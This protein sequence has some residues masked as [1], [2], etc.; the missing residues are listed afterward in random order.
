MTKPSRRS[1]RLRKT[2][3]RA[4]RQAETRLGV[5]GEELQC[6][7]K[8]KAISAELDQ[9]ND[10]RRSSK[11]LREQK[12]PERA[13]IN[14]TTKI[15]PI[16]TIKAAGGRK[17][18]MRSARNRP[19]WRQHDSYTTNKA[20]TKSKKSNITA[21]K[22]KQSIVSEARR[23]P[24][25]II[26]G[27]GIS[28]LACARELS[29][30]RH[31][32]LVLEARNRLGGRL[33]TID[34]MMDDAE[35]V[36][37]RQ[38]EVSD[39]QSELFKVKKWSPVDVGGAFIHGTGVYTA[40]D[41]H[42][43]QH[44][45][46]HDFGTSKSRGR[47]GS[48]LKNRQDSDSSPMRKSKRLREVKCEQ[49]LVNKD[50]NEN[51]FKRANGNGLLNPVYSLAQK[52]RLPLH[53]TA[54][55]H[56]CLVDHSGAKISDEVDEKVSHDFNEVLDLATKCCESGRYEW[57]DN[58]DGEKING[59]ASDAIIR[60]GDDFANVFE[61]CK[62]HHFDSS[63]R[64]AQDLDCSDD[65]VRNNLF[66]WHIAN[67]EMSSGAPMKQL[68]Q[69][70][71]KDEPFGYGGDH[72]YLECGTRD[73]I[74]ALAEGFDCR[75]L[76]NQSSLLNAPN[77]NDKS[78]SKR[79]TIQCGIEV[80]GIKVIE[81]REA[82]ECRKYSRL[83]ITLDESK[84]RR[85]RRSNKG[86]HIHSGSP[87]S[88]NGRQM[89]L[90]SFLS[91][92]GNEESTV[93][94]VTTTCG[95]TLEADAVIVSTPLAILSVPKGNPG[96]IAFSPP[97][98]DFKK[99]AMDRLGVGT[100]NKCCM[101]F[102]KA[103]WKNL[104][105]SSNGMDQRLDFVGHAA[106]DHGKD[107][108]FLSMKN[109]PILVAI[110][111]GSEY[112]KKVESIHD[113]EVVGECMEVLK[114]MCIKAQHSQSRRTRQ[115]V[116]DI[117]IPDWP[118]DYFVSRWG[119]D[120]YSRGA[121]SYVPPGIDGFEELSAMSKPIYDFCPEHQTPSNRPKRPLIL[122]AG[123]A[124]TPYHPSTFHGAFES[125]VR[126]ACRLDLALE[127]DLSEFTFN[128]SF[129][130]KPTFSV[131][132]A[133]V[134]GSKAASATKSGQLLSETTGSGDWS[135]D[136]DVSILRGVES[137]GCSFEGMTKIKLKM[138]AS[139]DT[140]KTTDLVNRYKFLR[141]FLDDKPESNIGWD[142]SK[143]S[144]PGGSWLA[145]GVN[146][147]MKRK[148]PIEAKIVAASQ[149]KLL[150]DVKVGTKLAILWP[151][152]EIYY[153]GV[154]KAHH[155]MITGKY[156]SCYEE[157][158]IGFVYTIHYDDGSEETL[159]MAHERFRIVNDLTEPSRRSSR[160]AKKKWDASFE[161]H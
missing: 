2:P 101:S 154:V 74:T 36:S 150:S 15:E 156:G 128:D 117:T 18:P 41:L 37:G 29:E 6:S 3:P 59:G 103:F 124:T 139:D 47:D 42:S 145:R 132:R 38:D 23:P 129:I 135:F 94:H 143:W 68:G 17:I 8:R 133:N 104:F 121:F 144:F 7:K 20:K 161:L 43:P 54:G 80:N 62:K 147:T 97:L 105:P 24:R 44:V 75:G 96:H 28:G 49:K 141:S 91:T 76:C 153:R 113:E 72:S 53:A 48:N 50:A 84:L 51:K 99:N 21:T 67:L 4:S 110:Y 111:G 93:V 116:D 25:V 56:T 32:V 98:P 137:F 146:Q 35:T 57:K 160:S 34:L 131:R 1:S 83:P 159:N 115:Q 125:G 16:I 138:M 151:D 52:L 152:D 82:K 58:T 79:G 45:G 64:S 88:P 55:A 126:E 134:V 12:T 95:L 33:R 136:N 86:S 5:G 119:S 87:S 11:R 142:E 27:A 109:S 66:Q 26:I 78:S 14:S 106:K 46:S 81:R 31:D 60:P 90:P 22:Q 120:P 102:E 89:I 100:Y 19:S 70:W 40:T 30:R 65:A 73:I 118:I 61:E 71:N 114:K 140:H 158:N 92:Y 149:L 155:S 148:A 108:L 122:F 157:E 123:E 69:K 127:P 13:A 10:V 112:S 39:V 85:S 63:S 77:S 107:I 130:Y 9:N